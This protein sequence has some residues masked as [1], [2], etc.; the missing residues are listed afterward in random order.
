MFIQIAINPKHPLL[1]KIHQN[2]NCEV[3]YEL[4]LSD[5][6]LENTSGYFDN[7]SYATS[8]TTS[9]ITSGESV[10]QTIIIPS[11]VTM[12]SAT[13]MS[14]VTMAE[15]SHSLTETVQSTV[16]TERVTSILPLTNTTPVTV[17]QSLDCRT[18][19]MIGSENVP[20]RDEVT[21]I[22]DSTCT[23][24]SDESTD[25]RIP[26]GTVD[27]FQS[28]LLAPSINSTETAITAVTSPYACN[29]SVATDIGTLGKRIHNPNDL[30]SS[31]KTKGDSV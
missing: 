6:S 27:T 28:S 20:M 5:Q 8:E 16:S 4:P 30:E 23:S 10:P 22:M 26:P 15:P 12:S 24:V 14:P 21:S 7:F 1:K 18:G 17:T 11:N 9:E 19:T 3:N 31:K 29:E 2:P 25:L 13:T